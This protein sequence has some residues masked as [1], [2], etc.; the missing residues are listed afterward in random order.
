M[1][2]RPRRY[3][4]R[5]YLFHS[6]SEDL[7]FQTDSRLSS[8][9]VPI[10]AVEVEFSLFETSILSNSVASTCAK[11]KIPIVAYSPLGRGLLTGKITTA[12]DLPADSPLRRLDK[13]QGENLDHNL[14][15]VKALHDLSMQ[16]HPY[17]MSQFALS[18]IRQ[19]SSR[20]GLPVIVPI[21][22]SS[23]EE[24]VRSN[25]EN[26]ELTESDFER[27]DTILKE[28]KTVGERAYPQQ[29]KYLEG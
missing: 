10:A 14:R 13:Y 21:C 6:T 29:R 11:L 22:G 1:K 9:V 28:N 2:S 5:K 26:V 16:H 20:N 27:I 23:K 8:K 24:N 4:E 7:V 12:A 18:W 15:L 19:L 3:R 17:T 25:A